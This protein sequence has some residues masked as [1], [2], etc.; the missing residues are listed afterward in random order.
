MSDTGMVQLV[1]FLSVARAKIDLD[2]E[3]GDVFRPSKLRR[4]MNVVTERYG[5]RGYAFVN[6]TPDTRIN[7]FDKTVELG[8]RIVRGPEVYID[9]IEVS[10]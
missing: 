6:V 2:C 4:D 10:C 7:A 8:F 3:E 5:D 9:R 1:E